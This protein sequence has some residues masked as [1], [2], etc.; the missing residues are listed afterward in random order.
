[1]FE[2]SRNN[3]SNLPYA[4]RGKKNKRKNNPIVKKSIVW[5][6]LKKITKKMTLVVC[7]YRTV[8]FWPSVQRSDNCVYIKKEKITTTVHWQPLFIKTGNKYMMKKTKKKYPK[9]NTATT[10]TLMRKRKRN[11]TPSIL[12]SSQTISIK[13][14]LYS[15]AVRFF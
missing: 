11:F 6:E 5:K 9:K 2:F 12:T 8:L 3:C 15:F 13:F 4:K 10:T 14:S 7:L 1:M